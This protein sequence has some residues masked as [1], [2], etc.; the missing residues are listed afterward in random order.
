MSTFYIL[1]TLTA[2]TAM[3]VITESHLQPV[4]ELAGGCFRGSESCTE[5]KI[6]KKWNLVVARD[7]NEFLV[8]LTFYSSYCNLYM[9][10]VWV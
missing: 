6:K 3:S 10:V 2:A 8:F 5:K 4:K 9:V 7:C 1:C